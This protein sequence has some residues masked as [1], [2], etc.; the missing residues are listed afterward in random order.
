[1]KSKIEL[2]KEINKLLKKEI[3]NQKKMD[4]TKLEIWDSLIYLDL[5]ST[6]EH[7]TKKKLTATQIQKITHN[8]NLIKVINLLYEKK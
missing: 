1:M 7:F 6:I 3:I 2:I 8:Q 5:V 4:L